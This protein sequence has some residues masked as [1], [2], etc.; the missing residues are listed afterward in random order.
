VTNQLDERDRLAVRDA[1][2]EILA[3][4]PRDLASL[5]CLVV[6]PGVLILLVVPV[7]GRLVGIA[8]GLATVAIVAGVV[9]LVVGIAM[10]MGAPGLIRGRSKA[11][12]EAALRQLEQGDDDR[13][14]MLRAA[15]LLLTHA[16]ATVGATTSLSLSVDEA[17]KRLGS[18]LPLVV[19][20]ERFLL[21]EG[22]IYPAFTAAEGEGEGDREEG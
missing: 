17:R 1:L 14:V 13:E 19:E 5:G 18:K 11:A 12:A 21:A 15:T 4:Q 3:D 6:L 2:E 8:P 16:H 7:V 9:L 22:Q 10:W 20:V